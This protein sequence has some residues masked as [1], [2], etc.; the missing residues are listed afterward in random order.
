MSTIEATATDTHFLGV[1]TAV[2]L[3]DY[4]QRKPLLVR[5]AFP[6]FQAPLA[7]EDLAGIACEPG[8]L[9]RLIERDAKK[10][11]LEMTPGSYIGKAVELAK[12]IA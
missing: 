10:L 6:K 8:V 3:R 1:P 4:W 2:F 5:Q 11:L 9:A 12:R 7:P